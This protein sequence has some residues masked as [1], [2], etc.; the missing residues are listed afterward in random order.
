MGGF[1]LMFFWR[2]IVCKLWFSLK[3]KT[4]SKVETQALKENVRYSKSSYFKAF[5]ISGWF[6]LLKLFNGIEQICR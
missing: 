4:L 5:I 3:I 2:F 6:A 1:F